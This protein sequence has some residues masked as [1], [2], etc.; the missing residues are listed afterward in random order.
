MGITGIKFKRMDRVHFFNSSSLELKVNDRVLVVEEGE[1]KEGRV[2]I[3][4]E[5]MLYSDGQEP[6]K[7]ILRKLEPGE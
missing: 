4:P 2:V 5:Q 3:S 7:S 1:V 6:Q